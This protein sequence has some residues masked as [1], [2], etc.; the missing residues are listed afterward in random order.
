ME[1]QELYQEELD[2][3]STFNF[4]AEDVYR[5]AVSK[6]WWDEPRED[7]TIIALI[8]SEL[9]EALEYLRKGNKPSDHIPEFTGIEEE[10]ADVIIRIMDH[11]E[12]N[13]Y[14]TAEAVIAK[15]KFNRERSFKHG[16]KKF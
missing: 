5:N 3:I 8:H 11:S 10:Y 13:H 14:R 4:I 15:M 16:G 6:G 1:T 2:F 7:G 9:S 12:R